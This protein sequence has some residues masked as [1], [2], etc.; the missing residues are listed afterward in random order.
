MESFR[1]FHG[2]STKDMANILNIPVATY[3]S[4]ENNPD[5][6]TVGELKAIIRVLKINPLEIMKLLFDPHSDPHPYS[7]KE[8]LFTQMGVCSSRKI[9]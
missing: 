5:S 3:R 8:K 6:F 1:A 9:V 7:Q 4:K 2:L